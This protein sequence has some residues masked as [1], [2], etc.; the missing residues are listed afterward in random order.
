[1]QMGTLNLR[2]VPISI[3]SVTS[4][5]LVSCGNEPESTSAAEDSKPSLPNPTA[6]ERECVDWLMKTMRAQKKPGN[7][8]GGPDSPV[9]DELRKEEGL[10]SQMYIAVDR[11][12]VQCCRILQLSSLIRRLN[13]GHPLHLLRERHAIRAITSCKVGK[14]A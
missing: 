11:G 13:V 6:A 12:S 5:F 4:L 3:A 10:E 2:L 1:M 8:L 14:V 7:F 9:F